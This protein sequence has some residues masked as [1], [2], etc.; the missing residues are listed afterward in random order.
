MQEQDTQREKT[1]KA[2]GAAFGKYN[3]AD[4]PTAKPWQTTPIRSWLWKDVSK[5]FAGNS[6]EKFVE[7]HGLKGKAVVNPAGILQNLE[8][9]F[10]ESVFPIT[11]ELIIAD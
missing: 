5:S 10:Y 6:I 2:V 11:W 3:L 7:K 1:R 8:G 9:Y 4:Y